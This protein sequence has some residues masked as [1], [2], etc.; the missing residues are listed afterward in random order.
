MALDAGHLGSKPW[1]CHG[2]ARPRGQVPTPTGGPLPFRPSEDVG[3]GD[4]SWS[5]HLATSSGKSED[6][7]QHAEDD[8]ENLVVPAPLRRPTLSL[9]VVFYNVK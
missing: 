7:S 2:L 6:R 3:W 5:C 4:A 8:A 9:L 1:T